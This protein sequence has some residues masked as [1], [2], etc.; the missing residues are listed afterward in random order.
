VGTT[1]PFILQVD[2]V[3]PA[4]EV[5]AVGEADGLVRGDPIAR[6]IAGIARHQRQGVAA[7]EAGGTL[8][9]HQEAAAHGVVLGGFPGAVALH[10]GGE[11][12]AHGPRCDAVVQQ[13]ADGVRLVGQLRITGEA[14]E[15]EVERIVA[16]LQRGDAEVGML[17]LAL[18]EESAVP[19]VV[20]E[21][22]E[23]RR[24]EGNVW[25]LEA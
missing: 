6:R 4:D 14:G 22:G 10:A 12:L 7:G 17:P 3:G 5:G 24:L 9:L 25:D 11:G 23:V 1:P 13:V 21:D 18:V 8:A 16:L 15:L 19:V 2:A 20:A